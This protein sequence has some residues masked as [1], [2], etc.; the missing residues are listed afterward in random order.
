MAA[1]REPLPS[2]VQLLITLAAIDLKIGQKIIG[3]EC[4]ADEA[5][6]ACFENLLAVDQ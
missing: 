2:E 4:R 6:F 1:K 3:S 5:L